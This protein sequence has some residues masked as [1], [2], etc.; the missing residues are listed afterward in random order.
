MSLEQLISK[1]LDG[2]LT[3]SE[4]I[5][6]RKLISSQEDARTKFESSVSLHM[7]M[8]EDAD[9][10]KAPERLLRQTEDLILMEILNEPIPVV[11]AKKYRLRFSYSQFAFAAV[12]LLL[13]ISVFEISDM[14]IRN[15][16]L[17][18]FAEVSPVVQ[19]PEKITDDEFSTS[20]SAARSGFVA[21]NNVNAYNT[22][23]VP[24]VT[25][26]ALRSEE[27]EEIAVET[28]SDIVLNSGLL[29]NGESE[30]DS[31]IYDLEESTNLASDN[32]EAL[33][34]DMDINSGTA[35]L[36][37]AASYMDE[38][39]MPLTRN[40][41]GSSSSLGFLPYPVSVNGTHVEISTFF[42]TDFIRVGL[43]AENTFISHFSQSIAYGETKNS[44]FGVEFGYTEYSYD[45][46]MTVTVPES[47]FGNNILGLDPSKENGGN[48]EIPI[49][50][51]RKQQV[52]WGT[53]FYEHKLMDISGF[54]LSARLG[55]GASSEGPI[56]LGRLYT[57]YEIV[58]GIS[59]T[60]GAE[61]RLFRARIPRLSSDIEWKSSCSVVYGIQFGF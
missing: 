25:L 51:N 19:T 30:S 3:Q 40:V 59:L 33:D 22:P 32:F 50:L 35:N 13:F 48:I 34:D 16:Y 26:A 42:G 37:E 57:K 41:N 44:K 54:S 61:S 45:E 9:S 1:Y 46:S 6:L 49:L 43:D 18:E 58:N 56:G 8:R 36:N 24:D 47:G 28:N 29:A 7:A 17:Q 53:A 11:P 55:A 23:T 27:T 5:Q 15:V 31:D 4:D 20:V 10:I 21:E 52:F 14:Q 12:F 2:E 39:S 60:L 38:L